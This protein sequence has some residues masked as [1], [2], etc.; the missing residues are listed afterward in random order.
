MTYDAVVVGSG[1]GVVAANGVGGGS[2]VYALL[3]RALLVVSLEV[4]ASGLHAPARLAS[5]W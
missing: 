5:R 2:L 4:S 3:R 1:L